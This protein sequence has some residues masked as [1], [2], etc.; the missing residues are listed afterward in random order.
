[1]STEKTL[2]EKRSAKQFLVVY[3]QLEP[4]TPWEL[5]ALDPLSTMRTYGPTR[6]FLARS[7]ATAVADVASHARW[8]PPRPFTATIPPR[9]ISAAAAPIGSTESIGE[10]K[11]STA[12]SLGPQT[13]HAFGCAWKR[14][15][16]GESYSRWQSG[17]MRNAFI[18]VFGRS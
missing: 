11:R 18:V 1:M 17:H 4:G 6:R 15:S 7:S 8:N 3:R 13:G 12:V 5:I 10:P 9:R 2:Y 14:R 16:P